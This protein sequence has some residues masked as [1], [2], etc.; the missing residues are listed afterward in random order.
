MNPL[1]NEA[2]GLLFLYVPCRAVSSP[3]YENNACEALVR[4]CQR[5]EPPWQSPCVNA[6]ADDNSVMSL[7]V[8]AELGVKLKKEK[9][10]VVDVSLPIDSNTSGPVPCDKPNFTGMTAFEVAL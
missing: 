1:R 4:T 8:S 5:R 10:F 6:Y 3:E 2:I 9:S 7:N